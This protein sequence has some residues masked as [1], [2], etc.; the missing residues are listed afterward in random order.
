MACVT[1]DGKP[2]SSGLRML[3]A[4][5]DGLDSPEKIAAG[6]NFPLFQ[7]RSGLRELETA[8]LVSSQE[9]KYQLE[10][11]GKELAENKPA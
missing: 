11:K 2:T 8:G 4:L 1:P 3:R 5:K 7:V 9:G 6:T 10:P